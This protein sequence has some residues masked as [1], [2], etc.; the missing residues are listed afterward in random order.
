MSIT[1]RAGIAIAFDYRDHQHIRKLARKRPNA[2]D[3]FSILSTAQ[4]DI[5][6]AAMRD[7]ELNADL[8][9]EKEKEKNEK[10]KEK[11]DTTK[12]KG[13][14]NKGKGEK[15]P[16]DETAKAPVRWR[17]NWATGPT[18]A[19]FRRKRRTRRRRT[20][21]RRPKRRRRRRNRARRKEVIRGAPY[22]IQP[23]FPW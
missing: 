15:A 18:G 4:A 10:E 7:F 21:L 23:L 19:R 3:Y 8:Q 12:G 17:R 5:K 11:K 13:E 6:A 9:K 20:R 2:A 22:L 1:D 16:N 14:G